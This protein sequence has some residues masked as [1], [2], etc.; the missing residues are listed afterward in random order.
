M[1]ILG[2]PL[3]NCLPGTFHAEFRHNMLQMFT[4]GALR[5]MELIGY[6]AI[7]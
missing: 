1:V 3:G 7:E 6:F 2:Q 4:H 5:N